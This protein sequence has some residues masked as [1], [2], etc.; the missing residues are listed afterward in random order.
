M[1]DSMNETIL[2]TGAG[3][4]IGSHF[5]EALL[6]SKN[7]KS[8]GL[9]L[10]LLDD[11]STGHIE[12]IQTLKSIGEEKGSNPLVFEQVSLLDVKSLREV[13]YVID[14]KR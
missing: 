6:G 14:R 3:G 4:Y 8:R 12:F 9:N 1:T 5:V 13:F 11:L 2:I 7:W 10:V